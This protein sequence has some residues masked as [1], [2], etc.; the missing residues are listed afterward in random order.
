MEQDAPIAALTP[1]QRQ[2]HEDNRR[3]WNAA[4]L[5]H[6]SH[7]GDQGAALRAGVSTLF[8]EEVE[9]CGALAGRALCHLQ[10]NAGQDTLSLARLGARVTGVDISDEAVA[11]AT[12]LSA[13]SGLPGDFVRADVYDYLAAAPTGSFDIVFSSYGAL[14]WLSDLPGWARGVAR[15]LRP[16]GRLAIMEFHPFLWVFDE[17]SWVPRFPYFR[18]RRLTWD[19]GIGDYV[20]AS[21]EGLWPWGFQ[22]GVQGFKNPHRCHEFPYGIGDLMAAVL[23]AGLAIDTFREY[24]YANGCRLFPTLVEQAGRR[25]AMPEGMPELPMMYA[26][27]AQKPG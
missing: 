25:F 5:A 11:A 9:L 15:L 20:A 1:E 12:A 27:G 24:P 17:V 2:L 6:N 8:P 22:A 16:G 19:D 4:T 23:G 26:L 13:A 10:C 3:S 21:G 14:G 7:K 18:G